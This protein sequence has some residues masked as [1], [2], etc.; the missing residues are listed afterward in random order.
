VRL[1]AEPDVEP[2]MPGFRNGGKTVRRLLGQE[3]AT[4]EAKAA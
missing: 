4:T 1:S 3:P 2:L